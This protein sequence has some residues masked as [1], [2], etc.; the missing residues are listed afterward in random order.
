M[1]TVSKKHIQ[2]LYIYT[3]S[4]NLRPSYSLTAYKLV[5]T[6]CSLLGS[7]FSYYRLV[8]PDLKNTVFVMFGQY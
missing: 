2:Y 3:D 4:I 1:L 5:K 7:L 8:G 6:Q